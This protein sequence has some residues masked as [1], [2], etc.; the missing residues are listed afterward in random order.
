MSTVGNWQGPKIIKDG[1]VMYL[2]PGSPNS[3]FNKTSTTIKDISGNN[4][5]GTLTNGPTYSTS[6]GGSIIFDGSDDYI[7]I[8]YTGNTSNSYT[9]N[10]AMKCNTM[11]SNSGNR[12][13]ILGLSYNNNIA[14][15]QF[16]SEI[17]GNVGVTFRGNGGSTEG[18]D[19]F[20]NSWTTNNDANNITYYTIII[21]STNH[22]MYINNVLKINIS[23]P[24]TA[25]FNS[26]LLGGR[27]QGNFWNGGCY[28]F[29]M[30][31]RILT[32]NE[33]TQNYNVVK[34]RFGL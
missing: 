22:L 29:Q 15:Q 8:P 10:I 26:I 19:F 24:Y 6:N 4:R 33:L 1:L 5:T 20:T 32:D 27:N 34:S 2:D 7:L 17:W 13:T 12:Q 28:L 16:T 25:N 30:Y 14:Y 11:D 31:D 23:R 9:F 21:N 18:V 3:Y